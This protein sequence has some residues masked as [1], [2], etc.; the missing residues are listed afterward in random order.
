MCCQRLSVVWQAPKSPWQRKE[1]LSPEIWVL[2]PLLG[3]LQG[4]F[5][6][7]RDNFLSCSKISSVF[8]SLW[9]GVV[10]AAWCQSWLGPHAW[11]PVDLRSCRRNT[12]WE[13]V[14]RESYGCKPRFCFQK[15]LFFFSLLIFI[16][17]LEMWTSRNLETTDIFCFTQIL[18]LQFLCF[19]DLQFKIDFT[20]K[21]ETIHS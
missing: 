9:V 15:H 18:L 8:G 17:Y 3:L 21:F 6:P 20:L 13:G 11:I 4:G 19:L 14:E 10:E 16:R 2:G 12:K 5:S 1:L 7:L